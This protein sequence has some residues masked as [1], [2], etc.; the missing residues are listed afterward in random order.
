MKKLRIRFCI[1]LLTAF[2]FVTMVPLTS[3]AASAGVY[4]N[5][6][7]TYSDESRTAYGFTANCWYVSS[8]SESIQ[9]RVEIT[10]MS[11]YA[12]YRVV[13]RVNG[14]LVNN[15][16]SYI[17]YTTTG[18]RYINCYI[19]GGG[20]F[21]ITWTVNQNTYV[22][23]LIY[24]YTSTSQAVSSAT[25]PVDFT[26]WKYAGST[27]GGGTGGNTSFAGSAGVY[28]YSGGIYSDE[29]RTAYGFTANCWYMNNLSTSITLRVTI[30]SLCG[31]SIY[32]LV[33]VINGV[34]VNNGNTY[35]TFYSE[36]AETYLTCYINGGGCF[37]STW[38]ISPG[39][40]VDFLIYP[41]HSSL[42]NANQ[43]SGGPIDFTFW[44]YTGTTKETND[45]LGVDSGKEYYLKNTQISK[46]MDVFYAID[47]EGQSVTAS[48]FNGNT[49]QKW[50]LV[51]N[52]DGTYRIVTSLSSGRV[53]TI[54]NG[55]TDIRT[56]SS[57]NFCQ[58]FTLT[59]SNSGT[60][61]IKISSYNEYVGTKPGDSTT[62][63]GDSSN[64]I[65]TSWTLEPVEKRDADFYDF[66][67]TGYDS[68]GAWNTFYTQVTNIGYRAYQLQN[69][70]A[71]LAYSYMQSDSIWVFHG[72][73][74][75]TSLIHTPMS[76]II[77]KDGN[78]IDNGYITPNSAVTSYSNDRSIDSLDGNALASEKCILYLGCSTGVAYTAPGGTTYNLLEST[79]NKG[80]HFVLGTTKT[81]LNTEND[82]WAQKFFE[83]AGASKT[84]NQCILDAMYYQNIGDINI[85]GDTGIILSR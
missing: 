70:S 34:P 84:I 55:K 58:I 45:A 7:G 28:R 30:S 80:A 42:G 24:G 12:V 13:P 15:G 38:N 60:Y 2:L 71:A 43:P 82:K 23:F 35:Y 11:G 64:N 74:L 16:N 52:G 49:N 48:E 62:I 41:Y 85:K 69:Y 79:Y 9:L 21:G 50:K 14:N 20:D 44:K 81:V 6:G 25:S 37:G 8:M 63:Y 29:S 26:F 51:N 36:T 68:T 39:Q 18:T 61:L 32:R 78:G 22:D 66:Y 33:P 83:S 4:R 46:Y 72:H 77:F 75:D 54:T 19:N 3:F 65:Y 53:L 31:C 76:T 17:S 10:S 57:T 67:Y 27:S 73:G 47:S 40:Y 59:R 1:I 56:Y 5:S